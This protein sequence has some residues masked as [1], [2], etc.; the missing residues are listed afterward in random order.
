VFGRFFGALFYEGIPL[1]AT[2]AFAQPLGSFMTAI[3][4]KKGRFCF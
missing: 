1:F 2:G 4:T 3:L